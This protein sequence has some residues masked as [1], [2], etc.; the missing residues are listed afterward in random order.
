MKTLLRSIL[1]ALAGLTYMA[2]ISA[3]PAAAA[4]LSGGLAAN[5]HAAMPHDARSGP[6][7]MA[8]YIP[9][10]PL[11]MQPPPPAWLAPAPQQPPALL[12]KNKQLRKNQAA[13]LQAKRKKVK[14]ACNIR[15]CKR[16]YRSFRAADCTFQ[17]YHGPRKLCRK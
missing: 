2:A 12:R 13:P 3:A 8:Q 15:A 17:P 11:G 6:V 14:P 5:V 1:P 9:P 4:G 16:A 10:P 7:H